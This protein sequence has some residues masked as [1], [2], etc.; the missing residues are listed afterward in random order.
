MLKFCFHAYPFTGRPEVNY[1]LKLSH[2]ANNMRTRTNKLIIEIN[3]AARERKTQ[4][5]HIAIRINRETLSLRLIRQPAN[6]KV[7]IKVC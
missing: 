2:E 4:K 7:P 3:S 6:S 5:S 1:S